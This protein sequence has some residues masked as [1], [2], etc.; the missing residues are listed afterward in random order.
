MPIVIVIDSIGAKW[1]FIF[2]HAHQR[3]KINLV[4][5]GEGFMFRFHR[6]GGTQSHA[7]I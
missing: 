7:S 2:T 4:T 5:D 3:P 1:V 6:P